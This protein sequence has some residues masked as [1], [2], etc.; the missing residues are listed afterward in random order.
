MP[1]DVNQETG[2]P[3]DW[4]VRHS[5][6]KQLPY[7]FNTVTRDSRWD[8]PTGSDVDK[9]ARYMEAFSSSNGGAAAGPGSGA[10]AGSFQ[11]PAGKVWASHLLVK[12]AGSRRPSS[13]REANITRSKAEAEVILKGYEADIR[14]GRTT[15]GDLAAQVSDCSSARKQG[16]LGVFSKGDMQR[17]FEEVA[18]ALKPGEMSSIVDTPSG[19]HLIERLG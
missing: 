6:S 18:F 10:S 17:E 14:A 12:H 9:L 2:L 13:W 7:Y 19:L 16:D 5:K 3:L 4:E 15:L 8:P 1:G 11:V